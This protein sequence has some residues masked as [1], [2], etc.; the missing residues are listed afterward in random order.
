MHI[1]FIL[2]FCGRGHDRPHGAMGRGVD[3]RCRGRDDP[4][5]EPR[6]GRGLVEAAQVVV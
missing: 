6:Q 1:L 3:D 5:L 4:Q 2:F